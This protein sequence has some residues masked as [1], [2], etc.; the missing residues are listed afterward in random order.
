MGR[1]LNR[2]GEDAAGKLLAK[3]PEATED[4]R[5]LAYFLYTMCERKG[6]ADDAR[7]Y[8]ELMTSW[9]AIVAAS[10]EHIKTKP[11][12]KELF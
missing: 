4:I 10:M 7:Y 8:N 6:K 2:S 11:V 5:S 9:S 1:V 12:Q 3:M